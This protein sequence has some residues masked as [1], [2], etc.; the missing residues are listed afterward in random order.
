MGES[1][2]TSLSPV[3]QRARDWLSFASPREAGWAL[4]RDL[5]AENDLLVMALEEI[6]SFPISRYHVGEAQRIA[7]EILYGTPGNG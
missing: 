7:R 3:A 4:I 2:R 5:A 1:V 6:E